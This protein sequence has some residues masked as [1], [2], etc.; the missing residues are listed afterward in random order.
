M[1]PIMV[2][3][4]AGE[5]RHDFRYVRRSLPSLLASGLPDAA[6]VILIN[7]RSLDPRIEGFLA[8]LAAQHPRVEVW[9][10][11]ERMGP[12]RG[13]AYNVP[14]VVERFPTAPYF[15]FCDDDM[16]YHPG[17]LQRLI[18]VYQEARA[19]SMR[20]VFTGL[21][22]PFRPSYASVR[23]P[24]SEVLLK[25]RQPAF[26]WLLP[27]E[28]Y[29]AVGPFR[30]VGVAFDT[31][32]CNRLARLAIPVICMKPSHVQNIGYYGAY[33]SGDAVTAHDYVGRRDAYLVARDVWY[34]MRRNTIGRAR[35]FAER[36]PD[37]RLKRLGLGVYRHARDLL[38]RGDKR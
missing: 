12:N 23:L 13:Q 21:N 9:T 4:W 2:K 18:R 30:D 8:G 6:R 25:E 36:L 11:P 16:I 27:R 17:W 22:T 5:E 32:Y 3:V 26:N 7:D 1:F 34:C 33:Q 15:V 35:N 31:D 37:G 29:E 10:N 24:T 19:A 14:R 38:V 28:V 20:G